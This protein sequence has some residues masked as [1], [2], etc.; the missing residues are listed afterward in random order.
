[1]S[2]SYLESSLS[3]LAAVYGWESIIAAIEKLMRREVEIK[4]RCW[5]TKRPISHPNICLYC[6]HPKCPLAGGR[7]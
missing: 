6:K 2:G 4:R 3:G 1:M 5:Y 7:K